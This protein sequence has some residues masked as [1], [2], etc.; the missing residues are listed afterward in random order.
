MDGVD[1]FELGSTQFT[2]V[3]R[4]CASPVVI[5]LQGLKALERIAPWSQRRLS[6][7]RS[8]SRDRGIWTINHIFVP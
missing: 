6:Y 8:Q 4:V 5:W 3:P 7:E 1:E 2:D